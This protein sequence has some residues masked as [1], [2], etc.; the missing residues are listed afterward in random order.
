MLE[1]GGS[2]WE[3]AYQKDQWNYAVLVTQQCKIGHKG[4]WLWWARSRCPPK[5]TVT[6]V[7]CTSSGKSLESGGVAGTSSSKRVK[8]LQ[9]KLAPWPVLSRWVG[10]RYKDQNILSL[11]VQSERVMCEA[12][13][14]VR[15]RKWCRLCTM[16]ALYIT[17]LSKIQQYKNYKLP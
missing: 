3:D 15:Q 11:E 7:H 6:G 16:E 12:C 9:S 13:H 10:G 5:T 1:L 17:N 14:C 2:R 4:P 8:C